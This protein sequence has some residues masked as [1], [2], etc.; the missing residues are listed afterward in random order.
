MHNINALAPFQ[1][2]MQ[3][4]RAARPSYAGNPQDFR[5]Q[6]T[7]WQQSRPQFNALGPNTQFPLNPG[8]G[9]PIHGQQVPNT[10]FP[11]NPGAP[12]WTPPANIMPQM[13]MSPVGSSYGVRGMSQPSSPYA[14][15][16]Y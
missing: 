12:A 10:Q 5:Q 13:P 4:W 8:M 6:I 16:T 11:L 3:D 9:G 1:G 2:A 7:Q 14:L 15:P